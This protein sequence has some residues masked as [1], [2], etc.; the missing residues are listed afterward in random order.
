VKS[1]H[2][3]SEGGLF[4]CL[5]E[6]SMPASLGFTVTTDA[7]I[8]K[9]AFLFGEGQSRVVVTVN[10]DLHLLFEAELKGTPFTRIG[11]VN[12]NKE[13][14]VDEESWGY[15]SDWQEAYDKALEKL[16]NA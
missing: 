7:N 4:A 16:L 14:V 1:A 9:D 11:I 2:D 12:A 3:I 10:P 6:C 15:V 5:L 13:I 8:R